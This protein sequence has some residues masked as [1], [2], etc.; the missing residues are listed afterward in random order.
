MIDTVWVSAARETVF[1]KA[2][3]E[4][5]SPLSLALPSILEVR[6]PPM[7]ARDNPTVRDKV[8]CD[9]RPPTS[10]HGEVVIAVYHIRQ[11]RPLGFVVISR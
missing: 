10:V 4:L 2:D 3:F 1:M 8:I 7:E 5:D 9:H 6:T 11:L